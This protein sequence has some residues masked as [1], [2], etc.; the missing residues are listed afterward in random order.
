MSFALDK[1]YCSS[2]GVDTKTRVIEACSAE[3]RS[4]SGRETSKKHG[5]TQLQHVLLTTSTNQDHQG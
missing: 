5:Q 4:C 3:S 1:Q 2:T